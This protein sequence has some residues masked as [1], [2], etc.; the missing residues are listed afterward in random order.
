MIA[1]K[2]QHELE[3]KRLIERW[4]WITES[5]E[6]YDTKVNTSMVLEN[7]YDKMVKEGQVSR[8]W[9]DTM[10]NEDVL[11]EDPNVTTAN[12]GTNLIPKV[13][14][15]LIRRVFPGL[16]ANK[17]V[18]VQPLTQPTG[19]IY[20]LRYGY[21]T[22]KGDI[23][24]GNEF[25]ANAQESLPAFSAYYT[26]EK[27]GPFTAAIAAATADTVITAGAAVTTFLGTATA[28]VIKRIEV[29]NVDDNTAASQVA[30][31]NWVQTQNQDPN[32]NAV[33]KPY[34]A[35]AF[36]A[37]RSIGAQF[38]TTVA[39]VNTD[40]V[41]GSWT[42]GLATVNTAYNYTNGKIFLRR[43]NDGYSP[44]Q[45]TK[46]VKV[47]VVYN[48]EATNLQPQMSFS[49]TSQTVQTT[50]RKMRVS[51][52]KE[53]EQDM[54][55][56]HKIDVESELVKVASMEMNY[57]IDRE[58]LT[59][60]N[61]QI[62]PALSFIHD[63]T[64]DAPVSGNNAQGNFLD[65]HRALAQK[66]YQV[67]AKMAQY[68]RLGSATWAVVSPQVAAVLSMLPDFKGEISGGSFSI[69]EAGK[70]AGNIQVYVDPNRTTTDIL[71]GFKNPNSTYGAGVVYA[72]YTNWMSGTV[73]DPNNFN[74]IRG[75][76]SRYGITTVNRGQFYYG[77]ITVN[78]LVI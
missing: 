42:G 8:N 68:N 36:G 2:T 62:D 50:E 72:P 22:T 27:I 57:E 20:Y 34:T 52:T 41:A 3:E 71:L 69:Q 33:A 60:I 18:S 46:N 67:S 38:R 26:A 61:D 14:F 56:F 39:V 6:D 19:V 16:I 40:P 11:N 17:L 54:R 51:W 43:T 35:D 74:Q 24:A 76:F 70:L 66:I 53:S 47:F 30:P 1:T 58:L 48:Q 9:L 28:P 49:I 12:A 10:L 77:R 55:A 65:R 37:V 4:E 78:N 63:W 15:P 23:T 59:Y 45:A 21:D 44:W 5:I 25:H 13:M 73:T 29:Y 64:A 31:T 32:Y 7:S 75:F